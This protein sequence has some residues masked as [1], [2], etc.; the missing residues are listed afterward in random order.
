[1][2]KSDKKK[3]KAKKKEPKCEKKIV[4]K[5]RVMKNEQW[6][7]FDTQDGARNHL[8]KCLESKSITFCSL[9]EVESEVMDC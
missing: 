3:S 7:D 1:M 9:Q 2:V 8:I 5:Y 4:K 6:R